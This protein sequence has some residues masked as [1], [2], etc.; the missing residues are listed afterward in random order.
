M[1]FSS[2]TSANQASDEIDLLEL[3][4]TLWA[5]KWLILAV[6]FFTCALSVFWVF[7][8]APTYQADALLQLEEKASA[9]PFLGGLEGLGGSDP[10]SVTEIELLKSR[11][12]LGQAVAE[13]HLDW[14]VRRVSAAAGVHDA[15]CPVR[16]EHR[17]GFSAGLPGASWCRACAA[18][19]VRNGLHPSAS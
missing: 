14:S 17:T 2:D 1:N 4:S 9:N 6:T 11:L 8:T 18:Q 3:F 5:G 13:L 7:N 12:I 19:A 10:R 15:L 16:R